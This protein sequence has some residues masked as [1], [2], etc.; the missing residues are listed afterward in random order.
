[1]SAPT[2]ERP[3]IRIDWLILVRLR[4]IIQHDATTRRGENDM[5]ALIILGTLALTL[6][7][8]QAA[9]VLTLGLLGIALMAADMLKGH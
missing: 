3:G 7:G 6:C 9:Y 1:M 4:A 5:F 8:L 2:A